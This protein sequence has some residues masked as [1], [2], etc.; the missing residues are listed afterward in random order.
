MM[1]NKAAA[2]SGQDVLVED[3]AKRIRVYFG[4]AC[5][6]DSRRVRLLHERDHLPVYYFP[7]EDIGSEF[8]LS[9]DRTTRCPRKGRARYW[10]VRAGD[11]LAEDALWNYPEPLEQC[12]GIG[13]LAA[14]DWNRMDAWFEEDEQVFVHPRDPYTR[15]DVLPSSRH[16]VLRLGGVVVAD[17][18][19]P[20]LLL[21]TGL[22]V[23]YYLPKLDIRME[24]L[25]PT[26]TI[27]A[28]PYKGTTSQYWT[29][30]AGGTKVED[31][32]WCYEQPYPEALGIAGLVCFY[33]EK[34]GIAVDGEPSPSCCA[35]G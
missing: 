26:R 18:Y 12:P 31:G 14:F 29:V 28:C 11:R 19:R 32:A 8:L 2:L 4:G 24:L 9:S 30:D 3:C 15:I 35:P 1:I 6:A 13:D 22:P 23:R 17:S 34:L 5:V 10:S 25:H 33:A 7:L 27:T 16:V 21:E 20:V